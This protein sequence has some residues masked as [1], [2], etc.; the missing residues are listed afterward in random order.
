M[1]K[2]FVKFS[3]IFVIIFIIFINFTYNPFKDKSVI[4]VGNSPR[5]LG[6]NLGKIIDS[7]DIVIRINKFKLDGY[8]KDTGSKCNAIH[9]NESLHPKNFKNILDNLSNIVWMGTRNRKKFCRKFGYFP[10]DHRIQEYDKTGKYTSGLLVILH[11]LKLTGRPVHI[12][13]I[14]GHSVPGYYYDQSDTAIKKI[15]DD[16]GKMHNFDKE[17]AK[18][19]QLK[20][21]GMVFDITF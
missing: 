7:Y 1:T 10:W 6:K 16:M 4:V 2:N 15:N 17:Q 11:V 12:A 9:I 8:E 18:L 14:G 20:R 13:G 5:I 3:V 21:D 19:D